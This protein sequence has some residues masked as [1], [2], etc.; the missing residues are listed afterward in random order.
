MMHYFD[1]PSHDDSCKQAAENNDGDGEAP[2]F[3][4]ASYQ[5]ASFRRSPLTLPRA[6]SRGLSEEELQIASIPC[7]SARQEAIAQFLEAGTPF[8]DII[9]QQQS[10]R[11]TLS[12]DFSDKLN[13]SDTRTTHELSVH[14][15]D[16]PE[17]NE[18]L[19]KIQAIVDN[20]FSIEQA[21]EIYSDTT[22][23]D[24]HVCEPLTEDGIE[25]GIAMAAAESESYKQY[26]Q[27]KQN[28]QSRICSLRAPNIAEWY[29]FFK[30]LPLYIQNKVSPPPQKPSA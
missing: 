8:S 14:I 25:V 29:D 21:I 11:G 13:L 19:A 2:P 30:M 20:G 22:S 6:D 28:E 12:R 24:D 26:K 3:I 15:F 7:K 27:N 9:K 5:R 18:A 23:L 1:E 17:M 4:H 10:Q 16:F